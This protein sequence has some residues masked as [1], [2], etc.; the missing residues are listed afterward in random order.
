MVNKTA[1]NVEMVKARISE[2]IETGKSKGIL[3]YKEILETLGDLEMD[4]EQFDRVLDT[5]SGL[6]IE[7][8]KDDAI[9]EAQITEDTPE[10]LVYDLLAEAYFGEHPL[11]RT[12]LGSHDQIAS[13][14]R[15]A[16]LAYFSGILTSS[17]PAALRANAQ[18]SV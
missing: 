2:L 11:A 12:I 13:I 1:A 6:N 14:S 5:L 9:P 17:L 4:S 7:V 15:E 10:D 18:T 8:L 3:T 16:L